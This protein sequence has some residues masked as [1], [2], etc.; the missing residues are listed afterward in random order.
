MAM[1]GMTNL[2][3]KLYQFKQWARQMK[4][5][6]GYS[7]SFLQSKIAKR[8]TERSRRSLKSKMV[9]SLDSGW[10]EAGIGWEIVEFQ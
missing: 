7:V 4:G 6:N 1:Y 2:G 5:Q 3:Q 8:S 10:A 9:L